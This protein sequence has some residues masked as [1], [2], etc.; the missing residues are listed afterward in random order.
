M[1]PIGLAGGLSLYGFAGGDPI[2]FSDPFG[3]KPCD[4][5]ALDIRR[6]VN[7]MGRRTAEYIDAFKRGEADADHLKKIQEQR[8]GF[9]KD[10]DKYHRDGCSDDD[11]D[12]RGMRQEGLGLIRLP[13][14][15][16]QLNR[17]PHRRPS[18][19][20]VQPDALRVDP[21]AVRDG[22]AALTIGGLLMWFLIISPIPVVP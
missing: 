4:E 1:D 14:P 10:L 20:P 16:P 21:N 17:N 19:Y 15:S 9:N 22:A 5:R 3:L 18:Y 12:F 6:R 8:D 7:E 2:N 13:L 11:N